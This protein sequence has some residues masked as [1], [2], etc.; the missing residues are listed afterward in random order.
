MEQDRA[1]STSSPLLVRTIGT[2]VCRHSKQPHLQ[3]RLEPQAAA[4]ARAWPRAPACPGRPRCRRRP[5]RRRLPPQPPPRRACGAR[6]QRAPG[7]L[8]VRA[9]RRPPRR[10]EGPGWHWAALR[11]CLRVRAGAQAVAARAGRPPRRRL[12][13][14]PPG[15]RLQA[16]PAAAHAA[17]PRPLTA[18]RARPW[19]RRP[20]HPQLAGALQQRVARARAAGRGPPRRR[21][22]AARRPRRRP[23]ARLRAAGAAPRKR[24]AVW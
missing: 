22:R 17:A 2:V 10:R 24:P 8:P 12:L 14:R 19:A 20:R 3:C 11:A 18:R 5:H 16:A 4:P 7:P 13:A 1:L 15:R 6:P 9:A 21:R 23:A